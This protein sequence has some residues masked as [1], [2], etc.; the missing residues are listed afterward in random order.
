MYRN[1]VSGGD[2]YVLRNGGVAPSDVACRLR[3]G[4]RSND[5]SKGMRFT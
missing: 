2:D 3:R 5:V 4:G 1:R